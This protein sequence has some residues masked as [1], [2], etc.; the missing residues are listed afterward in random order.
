MPSVDSNDRAPNS[1]LNICLVVSG[2]NTGGGMERHV[3]D[4]AGGLATRHQVNVLAHDSY[5][6]LFSENVKFHAVGF[7]S[8]RFDVVFLLQFLQKI[9]SLQP[10]VV[11]VHGRKAA[12][13][14]VLTRR[15]FSAPCILTVHNLSQDARLY[16]RFDSVIAVS[17]LVAQGIEHPRLYTVHNGC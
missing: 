5:R 12:Q 8:W 7:T 1:E 16:R 10:T 6:S 9:R 11:H 3:S 13:V 2:P 17:G 14:V 4:L 15:F